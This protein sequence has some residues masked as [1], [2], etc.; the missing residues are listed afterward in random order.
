[1]QDQGSYRDSTDYGNRGRIQHSYVP[2]TPM[3]KDN[4]DQAHLLTCTTMLLLRRRASEGMQV[5]R[6]KDT[7]PPPHRNLLRLPA[8]QGNRGKKLAAAEEDAAFVRDPQKRRKGGKRRGAMRGSPR[9]RT[10]P[11]KWPSTPFS[12][13]RRFSRNTRPPATCFLMV[14]TFS[15][16]NA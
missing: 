12:V 1:M 13:F 7:K 9:L 14:R 4:K 2:N 16:L 15:A 6:S 11:G 3:G 8:V 10:D 5:T